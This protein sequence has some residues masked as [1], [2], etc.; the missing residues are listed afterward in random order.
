MTSQNDGKPSSISYHWCSPTLSG[1]V[2]TGF[3]GDQNKIVHV[4]DKYKKQHFR[5][6]DV[7]IAPLISGVTSVG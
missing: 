7:C 5:L 4:L 6:H 2:L 1:R 3:E